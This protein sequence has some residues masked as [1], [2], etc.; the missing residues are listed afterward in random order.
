MA[1]L[2][3]GIGLTMPV[4]I[5]AVQ[6]AVP[7]E[8]LGTATSSMQFFRSIGATIGVAV[9]GAV[10]NAQLAARLAGS[11]PPEVLATTGEELTR[12]PAT[13]AALAPDLRLLVQ[14]ALAESITTVLAFAVP[15]ALVGFALSFFL[16]E[17]P[18]RTRAG[19]AAPAAAAPAGQTVP[20]RS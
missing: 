16:R 19:A 20:T 6:N 13:I 15:V 18:L 12:S 4:V 9:L 2:G 8:H 7:P 1:V 14:T 17:L 3:G 11:V 5:L 10:L